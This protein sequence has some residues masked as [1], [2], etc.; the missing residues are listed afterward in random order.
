MCRGLEDV[1]VFLVRL[2]VEALGKT[3]MNAVFIDCDG[4]L[5]CYRS[6]CWIFEDGDDTLVYDPEGRDSCAPLE[7]R[8]IR[9]LRTLTEAAGCGVVLSTTWRLNDGQRS[10]L[11]D[12][13]AAE[14]ITVLDSTPD[15]GSQG[16]GFEIAAWLEQHPEVDNFVVLDDDVEQHGEG[17][18][19]GLPGGHTHVVWTLMGKPHE[20]PDAEDPGDSVEAGLTEQKVQQAIEILTDSALRIRVQEQ[21]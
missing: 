8:C 19:L 15:L 9:N 12:S 2:S 3:A 14:G 11:T 18:E 21:S 1:R 20:V 10:F 4:V 16:R 13:L 5:A 17:F 6:M 7:K